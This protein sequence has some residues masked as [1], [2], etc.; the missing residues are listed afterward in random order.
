MLNYQ[1][2]NVVHY[3]NIYLAI[4]KFIM[5]TSSHWSIFFRIMQIYK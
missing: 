5:A 3:I 4:M 2:V 1:R